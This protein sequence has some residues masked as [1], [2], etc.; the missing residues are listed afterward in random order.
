MLSPADV[1]PERARRLSRAERFGD[2]R[3]GVRGAHP[4]DCRIHKLHRLPMLAADRAHQLHGEERPPPLANK[5]NVRWYIGRMGCDIW[6]KRVR[7]RD[8]PWKSCRRTLNL[9]SRRSTPLRRDH[10]TWGVGGGGQGGQGGS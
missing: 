2:E 9:E 7:V 3:L 10:G 6:G 4:L 1:L 5:E 8:T